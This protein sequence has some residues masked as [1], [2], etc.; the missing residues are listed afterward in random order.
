MSSKDYDLIREMAN[1]LAAKR[2][3]STYTTLIGAIVSGLIVGVGVAIVVIVE[4]TTSGFGFN[5]GLF[6]SESCVESRKLRRIE[7][8]GISICREMC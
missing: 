7:K 5:I 4:D 6:R 1:L 8:V 3:E 2:F